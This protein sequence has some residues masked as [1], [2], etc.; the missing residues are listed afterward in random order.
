M[1]GGGVERKVEKSGPAL[2]RSRKAVCGRDR[3]C[4][5]CEGGEDCA[6]CEDSSE[7]AVANDCHWMGL[8]G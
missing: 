2:R 5:G 6:D 8:L 3:G 4:G 1:G 7:T